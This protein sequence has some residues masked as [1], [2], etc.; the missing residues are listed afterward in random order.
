M[1]S[2][3]LLDDIPA[4]H[5]CPRVQDLVAD[6]RRVTGAKASAGKRWGTSGPKSG[7]AHRPG[8]CS[9]AAVVCLSDPPA[10]QQYRTRLEKQQATGNAWTLLAQQLARAVSHLLQRQGACEREPC[11]PR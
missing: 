3:V 7:K 8:A 11:C 1:R 6:G 5:R 9:A 2:R 4:I 10:A